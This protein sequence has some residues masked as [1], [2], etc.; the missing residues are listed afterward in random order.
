MWTQTAKLRGITTAFI[1]LMWTTAGLAADRMKVENFLEV[2]GFDVA[3][4]SIKLSADMAPEMLGASANDFGS[5]WSRLVKEVFDTKL[6]HEMSVDVLEKTLG[7][8]QLQHA[9]DFYATDLGKRLVETENKA[10][11]ADEDALVSESGAAIVE[12]L[13][14]IGSDRVAHLNRLNDASDIDGN[15]VRAIQ[16]VQVRFLMAAFAAGVIELRLDEAGLRAMFKEQEPELRVALRKSALQN[17]AYT[18]QAFS[19]DEVLAYAKA[20]ETPKMRAVYELLNAV[21]Y[22][23]M[24]DR[25]EAIANRLKAMQPSQDL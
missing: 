10:H 2:T 13:T 3:L 4:E 20:L 21:Q 7:D 12:G 1:L 15:A 14:R 17:A 22:E 24:A 6:M 19:D 16:E 25:F 9:V 18:Y 8:D 23:I 5:E 11:L